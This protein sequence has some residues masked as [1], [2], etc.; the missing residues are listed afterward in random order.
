MIDICEKILK[1]ISAK[2]TAEKTAAESK[3]AEKT[4]AES[5]AAE[6]KNALNSRPREV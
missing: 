3:A 2:R 5:K 1:M 4:A 6:K